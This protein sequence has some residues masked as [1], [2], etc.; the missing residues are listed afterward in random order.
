MSFFKS[1]EDKVDEYISNLIYEKSREVLRNIVDYIRTSSL[2]I[3]DQHEIIEEVCLMFQRADREK[4]PPEIL[5]GRDYKSFCDNVIAAYRENYGLKDKL[6]NLSHR[7]II[8]VFFF[9]LFLFVNSG[10]ALA[11]GTIIID[12]VRIA[13]LALIVF[14][15]FIE[16]FIIH[17]YKFHQTKTLKA[18]YRI[19]SYGFTMFFWTFGSF[20]TLRSFD[21]ESPEL[22]VGWPVLIVLAVIFLIIQ[23]FR[24]N[25]KA[26]PGLG[27]FIK[28]CNYTVRSPLTLNAALYSGLIGN[29]LF[30]STPK[31]TSVYLST[32]V[33]SII[34]LGYKEKLV[35]DLVLE[36]KK[37]DGW[38][39]TDRE[40][41][42]EKMKF[43]KW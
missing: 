32:V 10:E 21:I 29:S 5:L 13:L 17:K 33:M 4:T 26:H 6:L 7:I 37:F 14:A 27:G 35:R 15:A 36:E 41:E 43:N 28:G 22:I 38:I 1:F 19:I 31:S 20:P 3:R 34:I 39:F 9:L 30:M 40:L 24:H 25:W 11:V 16:N 2:S 42:L 12:P 18:I 8:I 23:L